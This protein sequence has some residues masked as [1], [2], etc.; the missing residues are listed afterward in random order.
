MSGERPLDKWGRLE[1]E[2]RESLESAMERQREYDNRMTNHLM[3]HLAQPDL[4]KLGEIAR[5]WE[6]VH[7]KRVAADD[8]I[9]Q[10]CG[11]TGALSSQ[12]WDMSAEGS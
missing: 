2:W 9:R 5:L 11:Q 8:Y 12:S 1:V 10:L 6:L 3:Y 4:R 7:E